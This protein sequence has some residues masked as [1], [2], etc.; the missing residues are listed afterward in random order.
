MRYFITGVG[1]QL[2]HDIV[3]EL[4]ERGEQEIFAPTREELNINNREQVMLYMAK[5]QPDVIFHCAA[6]TKVD[7][8]EEEKEACY[9]TNVMGTKNLVDASLALNAKFI[10]ISTD[11]VF[12]G[13]K[14]GVYQEEDLT[15]PKSVYGMTKYLGEKIVETNPNH[16]I[17]RVSWVFGKNGG[18]FVKTMLRLSETHKDLNVVSDQI[19]SPTYTKDLA[20][21]LVTM[22]DTDQYGTYHITNSNYCSW[23]DFAKYILKEA[24]TTTEVHEVSTEEYLAL[25]GTKQAYRPRNSKLSKQKLETVFG[26]GLPTWQDATKRYL[27]EIKIKK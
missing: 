7:K 2:G 13:T 12:D 16:Y 15:N 22:S 25:T 20:E 18:N 3:Q 23:A 19:G 9:Q 26:E 4:K 11:Y 27:K 6:Y 21:I 8:A 24:G 17:A 1:G 10:Y 5:V 14:E